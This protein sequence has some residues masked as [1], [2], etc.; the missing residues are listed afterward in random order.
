MDEQVCGWMKEGRNLY[1][2]GDLESLKSNL[3][4][5]VDNQQLAQL[6]SSTKRQD[7]YAAKYNKPLRTVL[8]SYGKALDSIK[9]P[10][11]IPALRRH[12]VNK[13][14]MKTLKEVSRQRGS[15]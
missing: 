9:T 3:N 10:A 14:H 15:H 8:I 4:S 13:L 12:C 1:L 6:T 11:C 5:V 7:N 2:K